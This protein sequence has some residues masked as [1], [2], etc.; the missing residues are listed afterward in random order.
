ML[1]EL[2][3][4]RPLVGRQT[5]SELVHSSDRLRVGNINSVFGAGLSLGIE[6]VRLRTL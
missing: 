6:Q 1:F 5:R 2:M 4:G 3:C